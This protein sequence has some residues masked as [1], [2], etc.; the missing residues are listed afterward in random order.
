LTSPPDFNHHAVPDPRRAN[1]HH[2]RDTTAKLIG[3]L[4]QTLCGR[5]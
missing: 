1:F 5:T 2:L 4:L 3:L